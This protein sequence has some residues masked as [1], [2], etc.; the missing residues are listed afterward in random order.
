M[1]HLKNIDYSRY[2]KA[3]IK[4]VVL[5]KSNPHVFDS[6][7]DN[8]YKANPIDITIV[9]DFTEATNDTTELVDQA[10]DTLTILS[11]YIDGQPLQV[12][13]DRLKTVM[14]ELYLE[15]LSTEHIE[16]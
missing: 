5:N 15:A 4:V 9:E 8:L 16:A 7:I 2:E 6:L 12:E 1:E 10:E 14:K 13:S 11:N 3:Y